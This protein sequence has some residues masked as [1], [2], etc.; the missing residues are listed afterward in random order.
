MK[1]ADKGWLLGAVLAA[2]A[3]AVA[4]MAGDTVCNGKACKAA[5]KPVMTVTAPVIAPPATGYTGA[6]PC[7]ETSFKTQLVAQAC[8]AGGQAAARSAMMDWDVDHHIT[9]CN[10]C[11]TKLAPSYALKPDGLDQFF[12][13]GGQ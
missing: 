13:Q 10:D 9:S 7:Q 4:A 2:A 11:H 1:T 3:F 12:K 5:I 8:Q 6:N